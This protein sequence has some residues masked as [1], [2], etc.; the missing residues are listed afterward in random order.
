MSRICIVRHAESESNV[1]NKVIKADFGDV[2][3]TARGHEQAKSFAESVTIRPDLI[4]S[5]T[6]KRAEA[7]ASYLRARYPDVPFEV[8]PGLE[9]FTFLE[10]AKCVGT[11]ATDRTPWR[12]AFYERNDPTYCDGPGA[13]SFGQ[14]VARAREFLR[15]VRELDVGTV[16]VFTHA[17]F[18]RLLECLESSPGTDDTS[19]MSKFAKELGD[20]RI[21][22][23]Q[24]VELEVKHN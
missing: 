7:T 5:S 17:L 2:S 6:F 23:C 13:E 22:N 20:Y 3:L 4:I 11:T 21:V 18:I 24:M 9:E 15:R 19:L 12:L 1:D 16:Y 8:W 10:P 14:F